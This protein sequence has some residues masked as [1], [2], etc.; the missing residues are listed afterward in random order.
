MIVRFPLRQ[1]VLRQL[2]LTRA[3]KQ[4]DLDAELREIDSSITALKARKR[5]VLYE[6][7]K[8]VRR[9]SASSAALIATNIDCIA[10]VLPLDSFPF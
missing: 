4:S 10:Q 8:E 2:G 1:Q 7:Q 3:N 5:A 9:I 6:I